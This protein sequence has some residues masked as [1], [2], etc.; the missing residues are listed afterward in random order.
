[1]AIYFK[2]LAILSQY[3][4][5]SLGQYN[6][7]MGQ[8]NQRMGQSNQRTTTEDPNDWL[9]DIQASKFALFKRSIHCK[10]L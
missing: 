6:Q 5:I 2:I 1:M 10:Y 4:T 9:Y 8:F 3:I 7:R